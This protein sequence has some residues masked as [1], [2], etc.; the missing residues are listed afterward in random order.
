[1]SKRPFSRRDALA[2]F[3]SLLAASPLFQQRRLSAQRSNHQQSVSASPPQLTGERPGRIAPLDE[4]V[5]AFEF[6]AMAERKLND[7]NY[8]TLAGSDRTAFDRVT[9]RPRLMRNTLELDLS[10]E[11]FGEELFAPILVGPMSRQKRFHPEGERAMARG[12]SDAQTALIVPDRSS[13]PIEEI[14]AEAKT[15]LWYQIYP[16]ADT[17][18]LLARV[19]KAVAAGCKAVCLTVGTPFPPNGPATLPPLE[20]PNASPP[21]EAIASGESSYQEGPSGSRESLAAGPFRPPA[22]ANPALDW[23]YIDRLRQQIQV[24]FLLKGIMGADEAETAVAKG[25]QGIVVSNHGGRFLPGLAAP[26]AL[27]PEIAQAVNGKVPVLIDGSFRRGSDI[28]KALALGAKAVLVGRPALWGLAAYGAEGV[29]TVLKLLQ[30]ELA[31]DMTMCGTVNIAA[32]TS[33]YVKTHRR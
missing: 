19:E 31:G 20:D 2:G 14:A 23:N 7:E 32:I 6:E 29:Q 21:E 24:P 4:V 5:N 17:G 33:D 1:M 15:P 12:A 25:M 30:M 28:L 10:T 8:R 3:G 26:M 27:L 9:F 16:D 22:L 18:A 11:L 13:Y